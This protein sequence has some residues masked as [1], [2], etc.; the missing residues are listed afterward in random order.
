MASQLRRHSMLSGRIIHHKEAIKY[1]LSRLWQS[2]L[3]TWIT[4]A[5]I[6]IALSLPS[7][8]YLF[9][10]NLKTLADEK[11]EVPTISI[12]L[13]QNVS[14]QLAN[15]IGGLIEER[16]EIDKVVFIS[17]GEALAEM[18]KAAGFDQILETLT[19]N[20]LPHV[21]VITP[22]LQIIGQSE[23]D[24]E[25]L[26]KKLKK[27]PEVDQVLIDIEWVKRLRGIFTL[28]ERAIL[29]IS[30]LLALTVLLVI[31]NTI[32]LNIE[33]R[34]EEIEVSTL[35]GATNA[36]IQRPFLYTGFWYGLFGGI[37]SL[38]F[39]NLAIF[40]LIEPVNTLAHLYHGN[41]TIR[42]LGFFNT[43]TILFFSSLLGL[44][45]AWVAVGSHLRKA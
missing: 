30:I 13:K 36:Y 2:S 11:R 12:F 24:M 9:L 19:E 40:S 15:D 43:L 5:A 27:Y 10:S 6:A 42:G 23:S 25:E 33:N 29:I 31:G 41:F 45:G 4:L 14:E 34:K 37:L 16:R 38:V 1:S 18:S 17:R 3:S 22:Q 7:S 20:P 8:L 44:I 21:L 28:T 39:V 35:I 26:V 32:K